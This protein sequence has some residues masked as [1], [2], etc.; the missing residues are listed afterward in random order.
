MPAT[1]HLK[2]FSNVSDNADPAN[3]E[4]CPDAVEILTQIMDRDDVHNKVYLRINQV[5]SLCEHSIKLTRHCKPF[6]F[7]RSHL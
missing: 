1:G 3:C 2:M 5:A 4:V 6:H 7:L